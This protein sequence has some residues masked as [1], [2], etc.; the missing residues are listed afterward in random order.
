MIRISTVSNDAF[1]EF[2]FPISLFEHPTAISS[3][4]SVLLNKNRFSSSCEPVFVY[5]TLRYEATNIKLKLENSIWETGSRRPPPDHRGA[6][7]PVVPET[8]Y[9]SAFTPT[10]G[11]HSKDFRPRLARAAAALTTRFPLGSG[12]V[13]IY[14]HADPVAYLATELSGVDPA[15][16]APVAPCSIFRLQRT[17][18][19]G[20]S[21]PFEITC[22]GGIGHL[23]CLGKTEPCHPI[24]KFHDWCV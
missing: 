24:H 7:F 10:C 6:G 13:A 12:N 1:I 23:S 20:S 9:A 22:S 18:P 5:H 21:P 16:T 15:V 19:L 3:A 17:G 14:S 4:I 2:T 11:E 8:D